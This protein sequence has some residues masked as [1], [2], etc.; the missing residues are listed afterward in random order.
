[1]KAGIIGTGHGLRVLF[2]AFHLS[3]IEVHG[4][5]ANNYENLEKIKNKFS[6]AKAYSHWLQLVSD[7][8][9]T[10]VAIAVPPKYQSKIIEE[11]IKNKK[12][13]FSE[14]PLSIKYLESKRILNQLKNYNQHF[15]MDY[16]FPEH[17]LFKKYHS[18]TKNIKGKNNF[19]EILFYNKS[20]VI[21]NNIKNWK[22]RNSLGGG[23]INLYLPHIIDYVIMFFGE[24][25]KIEVIN[26]NHS[27]SLSLSILLKKNIELL[28]KVNSNSSKQI[29]LINFNNGNR[30]IMLYNQGKDYAKNFKLKIETKDKKKSKLF[31][32]RKLNKFDKDARI[33]LSHT[34]INKFKNKFSKKSHIKLLNRYLIVEKWLD[35]IRKL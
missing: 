2:H 34:L 35:K 12:K 21:K 4:I 9:I 28:L 3:K 11:C 25:K 33:Y 18:F 10:V 24:I 5:S 22:T 26:K 13:I 20:Y 32:D 29:H 1:M 7:K 15:I 31:V 6:I 23:I 16:I 30:N 17:Q 14:K 27:N 8:N 19:V